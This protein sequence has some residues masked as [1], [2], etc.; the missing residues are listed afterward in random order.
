MTIN[1]SYAQALAPDTIEIKRLFP[2]TKERVWSYLTESEKRAK[3]LAAGDDIPR[4]PGQ[5][6]TLI[7][8]HSTLSDVDEESP[9][10]YKASD[11]PEGIKGECRLEA[12]DP[13][14]SLTFTWGGTDGNVS[15]VTVVL[16][17]E[18]DKTLLTLTHRKLKDAEELADVSGGWHTHL[19]I[20]VD[21]LE[22]RPPR[23]FWATHA[24]LDKEYRKRLK[25]S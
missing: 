2:G 6:F 16:S 23:G 1:Q 25:L 19:D 4:E 7:F 8:R 3:W 14:H 24:A 5:C 12:I 21:V 17:A 9:G 15:E 18:G 10:Q 22:G 11:T 20:M 13:P